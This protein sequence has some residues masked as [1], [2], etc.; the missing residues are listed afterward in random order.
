LTLLTELLGACSDATSESAP[1][2]TAIDAAPDV[3]PAE[4]DATAE[5]QRDVALDVERPGDDAV[6]AGD[7]GVGDLT[8]SAAEEPDAGVATDAAPP[9]RDAGDASTVDG[10]SAAPDI[11]L[12]DAAPPTDAAD[13]AGDAGPSPDPAILSVEPDHGGIAGGT[14][15]TLDGDGFEAGATVRFGADPGHEVEA[16]DLW[17]IHAR[18]PRADAP[19]PVD[20]VVEWPDGRQVQAAGAYTY[21][22]PTSLDHA[23]WGGPVEG[24]VDVAVLSP[25]G[26][27]PEPAAGVRVFLESEAADPL[28]GE[29]DDRGQITFSVRHLVGPVTVTAAA[30]GCW[31][32]RDGGA[33]APT[34]TAHSAR[35]QPMLGARWSAPRSG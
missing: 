14:L 6:A 13:A 3:Q 35:S 34:R 21:V 11:G 23:T 5:A 25:D 24:A 10:D 33:Q 20:V 31:A 15:V 8:D 27:E 17:T 4:P 16:T 22:D 7:V 18:S 9:A 26:E 30:E 28:S 2:E 12:G 19:G 32:T 1:A 29:T